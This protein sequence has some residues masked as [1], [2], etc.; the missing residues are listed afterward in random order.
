MNPMDEDAFY[1][2]S[3]ETFFDESNET[4]FDNSRT[5]DVDEFLFMD[6][7]DTDCV[8][9]LDD[10]SSSTFS[11][12]LYLSAVDDSNDQTLR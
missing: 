6:A 2:D 9:V 4:S 5:D 3:S 10:S 8:T 1:T 11:T 7:N 12:T